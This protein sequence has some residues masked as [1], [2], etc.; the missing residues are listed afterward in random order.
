M[1]IKLNI[2]R[3]DPCG[4]EARQDYKIAPYKNTRK[5]HTSLPFFSEFQNENHKKYPSKYALSFLSSHF[6]FTLS[7][8]LI[9]CN[10]LTVFL[11]IFIFLHKI[12]FFFSKR[13]DF[14]YSEE[15]YF[16]TNS[17]YINPRALRQLFSFS[18]KEHPSFLLVLPKS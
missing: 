11:N 12:S 9:T 16:P 14:F 3:K 6:W 13:N 8:F 5:N 15:E 10:T 4:D 7:F 17:V 2:S 18:T 1:K